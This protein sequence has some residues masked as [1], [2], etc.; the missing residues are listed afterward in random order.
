MSLAKFYARGLELSRSI[1]LHTQDL[2]SPV[3]TTIL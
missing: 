1:H 3:P 2:A